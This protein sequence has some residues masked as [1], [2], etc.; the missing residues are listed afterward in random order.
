VF[1]FLLVPGTNESA[2]DALQTDVLVR[3]YFRKGDVYVH[4]E[5]EASIVVIVK[6]TGEDAAIPPGTLSQAGVM[7]VATSRAWDAK[8]GQS[9]PFP[10]PP[11]PIP[12]LFH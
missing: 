5:L 7:A 1:P 10:H 2:R 12:Y 9:P 6:T 3:R 11:P 4:S 8:Q